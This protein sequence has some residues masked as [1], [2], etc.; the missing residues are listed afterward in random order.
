MDFDFDLFVIGG[1][2]GGVRAARLAAQKGL[3]VALAEGD[4]MGGTCVIR[5]CVPKKLMLFASDFSD[6]FD[7]AR[8]FGWD[9]P[10]TRF[11][12]PK[13]HEKLQAELERLEGV[14]ENIMESNGVRRFK[15]WAS[16][17][18]EHHVVLDNGLRFSADRILIATGG[19]PSLPDFEGNEHAIVSDDV[20]NLKEVPKKLVI[21]G[22]G[23]IANEFAG[24]FNGMG[25][26]VTLIYRKDLI[27]RG[28]DQEMRQLISDHMISNG[29]DIR[30]RDNISKIEVGGAQKIVHLTSGQSI[31]CDIVLAAT[32]RRPNL[33]GL[34]LDRVGVEFDQ[35][36]IKVDEYSRTSVPSIFAIGDVTGRAALTPVAIREAV[37]FIATEYDNNPS[38]INY[39]LIPTAIF[40]RPE[41]G[42][43]GLS[44]EAAREKGYDVKIY[45]TKF[46]TMLA[47][48]AK[49]EDETAFEPT[50]YK[51]VVDAATDKVLG[52]HIL[53]YGS[54][55]FIQLVAIAVGM[56]ATKAQFDATIAVHPTAAE[57]LV[58][59]KTPR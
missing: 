19:R 53:G 38:S 31:T 45:F 17:D 43:I 52:V 35:N 4:R 37:N 14:Y 22:G 39:D 46:R 56:G 6:I 21:L 7:H 57:E 29:I 3:K 40:T 27:L 18:G 9:V 49:R 13:F 23:Y 26:D 32:G 33:E 28:Y 41:F 54:G 42:T 47:T 20:F 59:L 55:E 16:I 34:E 15:A 8:G 58:T 36:G 25:A 11:D 30:Y 50:A 44:E 24:I 1:G 12:W 51:I 5:G 48:F 10:Q 2:S